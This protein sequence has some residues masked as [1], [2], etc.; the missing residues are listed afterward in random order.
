MTDEVRFVDGDSEGD[1]TFVDRGIPWVWL[2]AGVALGLAVGVLF[3]GPAVGGES[4]SAPVANTPAL[5]SGPT[6]P[7]GLADALPGFPDS[8]VAVVQDEGRML[9][10]VIWPLRGPE[11]SRPLPVG[12]FGDSGIDVSG[13]WL[14]LTVRVPE[15]GT[16]LLLM[17]QAPNVSPLVSG[18]DGFAWHDSQPSSLAYTRRVGGQFELWVVG[19]DRRPRLVAAGADRVLT[20]DL[21]APPIQGFFDIPVDHLFAT[22]VI[23]EYL[24]GLRLQDLTIVSPDAGGVERAR[25]YGKRLAAGIAIIDKR[26][27]EE[28][29]PEVVHL[30]GEVRDRTALI[31]DDF[32][33]SAGT[34]AE[35]AA[36][37]MER[38]ARQ[39]YAAVTHGVF[40][41]G[42]MERLEASPIER[43]LITDSIETQP[44]ELSEKIEVVSVAPLFAEAIRRIHNRESISVLFPD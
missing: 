38:G 32:T 30:I 13:R 1:E 44:V 2:G 9:D 6:D 40:S 5:T 7:P 34:L 15:D 33:I 36:R 27:G 8:L 22:P 42:S 31:V 37:L 10:H 14:A 20:M 28:N 25:A 12:D 39:V 17:G 41:I 16:S 35:A 21:H 24:E 43:L 19:S 29:R 11:V 26:R 3:L 18:V 4:E 23:L